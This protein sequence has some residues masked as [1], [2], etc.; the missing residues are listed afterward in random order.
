MTPL[1]FSLDYHPICGKI[2]E[3]EG[4]FCSL[5]STFLEELI[6]KRV[7]VKE[8]TKHIISLPLKL[9]RELAYPVEQN[10]PDIRRRVSM[11][12]LFVYLNATIWNFI[13]Y[14]LLEHIIHKFGSKQ[15]QR[16]MEKYVADVTCFSKQATISHLIKYWPGRTNTPPKYCELMT[17]INK[18]PD[19]CTLEELNTLRKEFHEHFLPPLSEFALMLC[20]LSNGSIVVKWLI[21][22][23]LVPALMSEVEKAENSVFFKDHSIESVQVRDIV[24]YNDQSQPSL[25]T[26]RSEPLILSQGMFLDDLGGAWGLCY[27]AHPA[28]N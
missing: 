9:R 28:T 13:D 11:D 25:T 6:E 19:R 7:D 5:A 22:V 23:D 27:P 16:N 4:E 21:A 20:T 24:I 15:L 12:G 3:L 14:A 26:S 18:D 10:A 1:F 2:E 17:K 8:I